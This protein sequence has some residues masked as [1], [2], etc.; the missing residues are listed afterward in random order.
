MDVERGRHCDVT[1]GYG[2][3]A[4]AYGFQTVIDSS[5]WIPLCP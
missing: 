5:I 1:I 2:S 4:V 3:L